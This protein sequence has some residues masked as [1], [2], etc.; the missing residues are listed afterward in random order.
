M[1]ECFMCLRPTKIC[2]CSGA[3]FAAIT[4]IPRGT[5]GNVLVM[6]AIHDNILSEC[7]Y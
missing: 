1:S 4:T 5:I 6:V 3:L 2:Y 7:I